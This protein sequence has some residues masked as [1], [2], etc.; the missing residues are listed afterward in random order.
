[1]VVITLILCIEAIYQF[2][3]PP[4]LS[5]L[6]PWGLFAMIAVVAVLANTVCKAK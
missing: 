2:S 6:M 5:W 1:M 3:V 4:A